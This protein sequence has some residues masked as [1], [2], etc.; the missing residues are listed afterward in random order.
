MAGIHS[1]GTWRNWAG[2]QTTDPE[3]IERPQ[4]DEQV[5]AR[6]NAAA[7]DGFRI[8]AVGSGHSFTGIAATNEVLV[9]LDGMADVRGV[10]AATGHVRVLS[11]IHI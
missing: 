1:D 7:S 3:R 2:H 4:N 9:T 8:R 5:V 6:V 11:L 10:D